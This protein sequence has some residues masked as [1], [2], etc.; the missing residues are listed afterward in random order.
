[1]GLFFFLGVLALRPTP[2]LED[3]PV[4]AIGDRLLNIFEAFASS[5]RNVRAR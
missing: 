3:H 1:M 4:S 2:R 5:I